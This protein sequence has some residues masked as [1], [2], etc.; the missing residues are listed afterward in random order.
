MRGGFGING[1]A[2]ANHARGGIAN[3]VALKSV[4]EFSTLLQLAKGDTVA[5]MAYFQGAAATLPGPN[6]A[7]M[8][9]ASLP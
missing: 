6:L 4:L 8:T 1:A 9:I 7:R 2:P 5:G 3:P